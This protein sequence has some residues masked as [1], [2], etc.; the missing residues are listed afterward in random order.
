MALFA[1]FFA[2]F[3]DFAGYVNFFILQ[4][5]V[6]DD[7]RSVRSFA[8]FAD[9][10]TPPIPSTVGEYTDYRRLKLNFVAASNQRITTYG[11]GR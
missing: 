1:D 5:L 3:G 10:T 6:Y 7:Y 11:H 2:L 9:F 4:D 8:P